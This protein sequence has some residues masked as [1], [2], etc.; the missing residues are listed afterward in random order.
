LH[1]EETS[2][3]DDDEDTISGRFIVEIPYNVKSGKYTVVVKAET[4][5]TSK[6]AKKEITIDN[7]VPELV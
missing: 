2:D 1:I 4:E 3:D 6:T 5:E 7:S